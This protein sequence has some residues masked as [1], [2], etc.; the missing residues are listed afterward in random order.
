M[1]RDAEAFGSFSVDDLAAARRFY[2]NEP[3]LPGIDTAD[4]LRRAEAHWHAL[5][6]DWRQV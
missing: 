3:A 6:G 2:A 4:D 5:A 1:F